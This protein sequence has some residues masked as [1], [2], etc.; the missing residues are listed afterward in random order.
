MP[1]IDAIGRALAQLDRLRDPAEVV[2]TC[3][4]IAALPGNAMPPV[5]SAAVG[6]LLAQRAGLVEALRDTIEI[7][8][9]GMEEANRC[10][11]EF[12]IDEH[13]ADAREE[14]K[15]CGEQP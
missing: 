11:G 4:E 14:L 5:Y 6:L 1:D 7:A 10:C 12:D 9:H 13:L 2:K 3:K 8:K 15:S